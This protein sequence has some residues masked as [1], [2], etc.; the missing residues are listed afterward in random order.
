M[1][2][3]R[4]GTQKRNARYRISIHVPHVGRDD[5]LSAGEALGRSI[6]IHVPHVGRDFNGKLYLLT[7]KISIHVPHVGR[8]ENHVLAARTGLFISIHVPH[9]GRD[10]LNG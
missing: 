7:G 5:V 1:G 3:D 9:V 4:A 6:S 10:S 2:R 8:D